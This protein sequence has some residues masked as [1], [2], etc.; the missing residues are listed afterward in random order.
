MN[1]VIVQVILARPQV[2]IARVSRVE[3]KQLILFDVINCTKY[4]IRYSQT[5]QWEVGRDLH[6]NHVR[7]AL[8]ALAGMQ[9]K[10]T[11]FGVLEVMHFGRVSFTV[12]VLCP[13]FCDI[14]FVLARLHVQSYVH[15]M[16]RVA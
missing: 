15:V 14:F 12:F 10:C 16:D 6:T 11:H 9:C 5:Y 2:P 7:S 3:R 13:V 8:S 4:L 1:V